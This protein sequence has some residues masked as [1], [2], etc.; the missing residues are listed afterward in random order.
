MGI[1][2]SSSNQIQSS[3]DRSENNLTTSLQR[4]ASGKRINSAKDDAAALA[5]VERFASQIM[6][7]AQAYRNVNDGVSMAQTADSYSAQ[8]NDLMQRGRELAMQSANGSMSDSDRQALQTEFSNI[9]QE[10]S[11]VTESAEFNG[12]KLMNQ[13]AEMTF[14]VGPNA[15]ATDQVSVKTQDLQSELTNNGFYSADISS[16]SGAQEFLAVAD[17]SMAKVNTQRAEYGASM[18]RFESIGKNLQNIEVNL[19]ESKSR[20][21]DTDYASSMSDYTKN[22]LLKDSATALSAQANF[23][24][25]QI[26]SLLGSA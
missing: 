21:L 13:S 18:N 2:I 11:R 3:L 6:G 1:G 7:S 15:D 8:V 22:L 20:I 10:V 16:Q 12:Q 19:Q 4:L 5:I 14:Q 25:S 9:Q 17:D 26:M 24:S 23:S